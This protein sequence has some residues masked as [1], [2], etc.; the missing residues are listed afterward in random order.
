MGTK[1]LQPAGPCS[2]APACTRLHPPSPSPGR[3]VNHLAPSGHSWRRFIYRPAWCLGW[4]LLFKALATHLGAK[5]LPGRCPASASG[6]GLVSK[7]VL[8]LQLKAI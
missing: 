1:P 7:N 4:E 8:S 5:A 3:A 2:A 6:E